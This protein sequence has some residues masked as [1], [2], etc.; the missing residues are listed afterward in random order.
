MNYQHSSTQSGGLTPREAFTGQ[1]VDAGKDFRG[2]FG[3]S[4][5]YTEPYTSNDMKSR[6]G[7]G[8]LHL[9][10]ENRT[11]SVKCINVSTGAVVT[12]DTF[13]VVPTTTAMIK[14]MNDLQA[15]EGRLMPKIPAAVHDLMY[16]QSVS[17]SNMPTF[18]PIQ[19]PPS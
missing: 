4:L 16:N 2:A 14:L 17:K 8:I 15:L 18:L 12:R 10:T 3:S 13:K 11:G 6:I 9:P 1:R 19:P 5:V 7:Q